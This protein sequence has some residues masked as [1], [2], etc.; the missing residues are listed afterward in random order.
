M[1]SG[2]SRDT[3]ARTTGAGNGGVQSPRGRAAILAGA[4]RGSSGHPPRKYRRLVPGQIASLEALDRLGVCLD[5][6]ARIRMP[7][8]L[9]GA[10]RSPSHLGKRLDALMQVIPHAERVSMPGTDHGADIKQP[11]RVAQVIATLAGQ[12]LPPPI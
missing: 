5:T 3:R 11:R 8:V 4:A 12:V 7:T 2:C 9:L 1:R 6:Y 10:E